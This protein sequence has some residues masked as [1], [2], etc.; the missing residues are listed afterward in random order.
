M[1]S[2]LLEILRCPFCGSSLSL[3]QNDCLEISGQEIRQG[4]L[5]CQCCAYP[6]IDGIPVLRVDETTQT[7]MEQLGAGE[8]EQA[9]Y[10]M[11][12]LDEQRREKF[13]QYVKRGAQATYRAGIEILGPDAEGTYFLYRFSDPRFLVSQSVLRA[14]GQ[15]PSLLNKGVLDVC[16]GSGHLT[17]ILCQIACGQAV[18][19]ADIV[20]YKLWLAKRIVAP[21]CLPVCCN[22]DNPLPFEKGAFSLVFCSDA[23]PFIWSRRLL[24]CEMMRM[25]G[26]DGLVALTH[27]RNSLCQHYSSSM[28][29]TPDGYQHLFA[30][31]GARLFRESRLLDRRL[32]RKP[33][34]LSMVEPVEALAD[35]AEMTLIATRRAEV[36]RLYET[37]ENHRVDGELRVNP[38]YQMENNGR[39]TILNLRF[40]TEEYAEEFA[41]CKCYLA[42]TVTVRSEILRNLNAG[43]MNGEVRELVEQY[44]LLDL[45]KGYY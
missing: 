12:G 17:R 32:H 39:R 8:K 36:F 44:V 9:L 13:R 27:L 38:L 24:S 2:K 3:E 35:E 28:P 23:F 25:A 33:V 19:L 37:V 42:E 15:N 16:G 11:L 18:V 1:N 34:D 10:T 7:A 4:I 5:Y 26:D 31:L 22:A 20:F 6:V 29:L 30:D 45:P 21:G 43:E 40:P 41:A 14:I